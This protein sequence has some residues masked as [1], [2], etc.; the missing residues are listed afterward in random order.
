LLVNGTLS[1]GKLVQTGTKHG[2]SGG[3]FVDT[4]PDGIEDAMHAN[5]MKS[6]I[7]ACQRCAATCLDTAM[8]H[9]LEAGG[10]HTE[11]QHFRLMMACVEVCRA[12][13]A[14]MLIGAP[15][16]RMQ[17]DLCAKICEECA[18]D[19]E[20]ID[21]MDACV[22]ACRACAQECRQMASHAQGVRGA[23]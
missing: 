17:C 7:E 14:L 8:H 6:C 22:Q 3:G 2:C 16:H 23:A 12:S 15:H 11:P 21:G 20:R 13:A 5:Q 1:W 10:K 9:C 19:C 18:A 4:H